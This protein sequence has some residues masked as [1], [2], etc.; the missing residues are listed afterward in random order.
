MEPVIL[1]TCISFSM[2]E[3]VT[4]NEIFSQINTYL[5]NEPDQGVSLNRELSEILQNDMPYN[6]N[7]NCDQSELKTALETL[8]LSH[9]ITMPK[10]QT[11]ENFSRYCERFLE[12]VYLSKINDPNLYVL[13]LQNVD[14]RTYSL[15]KS[16]ELEPC[17][18]SNPQL[19]CPIYKET[20][21]SDISM[22][23]KNQL[24]ECKQTTSETVD[25]Y[26][27]RLREKANLAY[28]DAN[29]ADENCL[30]AFLK[31]ICNSS[32]KRKLNESTNIKTF[33]AAV[34]SAK[35]LE[36]IETM[37]R[38]QSAEDSPK[39]QDQ[40]SSTESNKI[41][42]QNHSQRDNRQNNTGRYQ[43]NSEHKTSDQNLAQN[44]KNANRSR[45]FVTHGSKI[46]HNNSQ[47]RKSNHLNWLKVVNIPKDSQN[48]IKTVSNIQI[49]MK[50]AILA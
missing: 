12:Y 25:E 50:I 42:L 11:G 44:C 23:I 49:W 31:G 15:L 32:L 27:Y 10:F 8:K 17:Q 48:R 46:L 18:K 14:N 22:S 7:G 36:H 43:K 5:T 19:F 28:S 30:L 41:F 38:K 2:T 47:N 40:T 20:V 35:R 16:V 29:L 21:Y 4:K 37:L 1:K 9:S 26:A 34:K 39:I 13:F 33:E 24:L 45:D 3:N 6:N